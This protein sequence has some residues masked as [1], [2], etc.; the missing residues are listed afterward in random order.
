VPHDMEGLK[1]LMGGGEAFTEH[2]QTCFDE[3]YFQMSNEPD[4][5]YPWLFNYAGGQAWRTQ[6]MV[7]EILRRNFNNSAAGIPGDDDAGTMSA[8]LVYAMMGFYPDCPAS[9]L[10][11]LA[12]PVFDK[13]TIRLEQAY[14]P[15]K[16][17][18]ITS[19]KKQAGDVF[20]HAMLLNGLD[21][22]EH[23]ITHHDIVSGGILEMDLGNS[24]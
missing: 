12:S 18:V 19:R 11:Q 4:I 23:F 20:A 7:R 15:G 5:A 21:Y 13:V 2:L 22:N 6:K 24:K 9:N 1:K 16:T 8:W 10:Y 14:Y 3:D 17:F